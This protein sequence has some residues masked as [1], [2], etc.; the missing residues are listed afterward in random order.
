MGHL[1]LLREIFDTVYV[2]PAVW[3]EVVEAGQY[4]PETVL[5]KQASDEGWL[6]RC[7]IR[8][9]PLLSL[10]KQLLDEGEA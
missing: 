5:I 4:Y 6:V 1:T 9:T 2:P 7:E 10:L 8:A 3:R